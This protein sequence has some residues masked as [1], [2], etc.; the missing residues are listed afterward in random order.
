MHQQYRTR[1]IDASTIPFLVR[2]ID[3]LIR[4]HAEEACVCVGGVGEITPSGETATSPHTELVTFQTNV[5]RGS[6]LIGAF[7]GSV[8]ISPERT[9]RR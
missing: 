6:D 8:I 3:A 4:R 7:I 5:S 1:E 2:V 9:N